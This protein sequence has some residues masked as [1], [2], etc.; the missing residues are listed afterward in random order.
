MITRLPE[1]LVQ[2][3]LYGISLDD[4]PLNDGCAYVLMALI[5]NSFL[6]TESDDEEFAELQGTNITP[7][8]MQQ[9][10]QLNSLLAQKEIESALVLLAA[11][12]PSAL[13]LIVSLSAYVC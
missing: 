5:F 9:I 6:F 2:L 10:T 8:C 3:Q 7:A 4:N 13:P 1:S 11:C 12:A